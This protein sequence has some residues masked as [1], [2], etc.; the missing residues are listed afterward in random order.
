MIKAP[1]STYR[2]QFNP[3]FRFHDAMEIVN[4]LSMLGVSDIYG[5][6]V[7]K[8]K[9]ASPHCYDV[10]DPNQLNPELG[11]NEDVGS[12]EDFEKLITEVKLKNMGWVQ[13]IVP[14]HM[15]FD[16]E[17]NFLMDILEK[18]SNSE[19]YNFFDVDWAHPYGNIKGRL[20]APILGRLYWETLESGEITLKYDHNGFTINYYDHKFPLKIETYS[21]VLSYRLNHLLRKLDEE[22]PDYI[23]IPGILYSLKQIQNPEYSHSKREDSDEDFISYADQVK[24]IKRI[25][26]ELYTKN[27]TIK[28]FIDENVRQFNGE[29]GKPETVNLLDNLLSQQNFRLAFWKMATEELNYRRFFTINGLISVRIED[30]EVFE[31]THKLIMEMVQKGAFTGLRIDHIDGLYDPASYLMNLRKL[32]SNTY[33]VVEKILEL[34]EELPAYWPVQGTTGYDFLNFVNS[35]FCD[36]QNEQQLNTIYYT[37]TRFS[38]PFHELLYEKKQLMMEHHMAGDI[39]NIVHYLKFVSSR[40]RQGN[41]ISW[42]GFSRAITEVFASFPVYRTYLCQEKFCEMEFETDFQYIKTA[43]KAAKKTNPALVYELDYIDRFLNLKFKDHL[44]DEEKIA[45]VEFIM[46]FQQFTGPLMAKGL[47]DTV[48]YIYN[49][50][51]SLNE[52]GGNPS[53]F[54]I[55][56]DEFH[57]FNIM[58]A[59][60]WPNSMNCTST[61][62][63]KRGED[64]RARINVISELWRDWRI[65]IRDWYKINKK[66]KRSDGMKNVPDLNDEYF[67][68]QTLVG[69]Y[70]FDNSEKENFTERIKEYTIKAVREAKIHTGW[71]KPD[72]EYEEKYVSFIDEIMSPGDNKFLKAFFPFQRKV[73]LYGIFNSL[74]QT[75]LKMTSPG[76]PDFYQGTELWDF[77][78][79]DPDNRRPVDFEKRKEY[80]S[81]ILQKEKEDLK[82][83]LEE[84]INNRTNGEIKLYLTYKT[85]QFRRQFEQ[86]FN[87]GQYLPLEITGKCSENIIAFARTQGSIWSIT[88]APRFLAR[89][90]RE[91]SMP[92]GNSVWYDTHIVLPEQAPLKWYDRLTESEIELTNGKIPIV[93]VIKSFPVALLVNM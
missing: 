93:Q 43:I 37:F 51:I 52:V 77:N 46:R 76:V 18:G 44:S 31:K 38:K 1:S 86:L 87:E 3:A 13:D 80:L 81:H 53:K 89:I 15:A 47:E 32:A 56:R 73:A 36:T 85:M 42:H 68:Y 11:I 22:D 60:K 29:P 64:V 10:V 54:G 28:E 63:T 61:H 20:L 48:M 9:K 75:I 14:N 78:L 6:P 62:D 25:L 70:P 57:E 90:I 26:W 39:D 91:D 50:L 19:F 69:S 27:N 88:I 82:G 5:S 41:D 45:W 83:L 30:S 2:L 65:N 4:Y 71:L 8:A 40:D 49:R 79:V 66:A 33:I 7:F 67:L 92:F 12:T 35:V 24:F 74:S 16:G 23:K 55:T 17:N 84:L 34:E 58:R 21:A 59:E 72:E